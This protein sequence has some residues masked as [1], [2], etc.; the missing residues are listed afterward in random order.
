MKARAKTG[1]FSVPDC[2]KKVL[3][4]FA[5]KVA[6]AIRVCYDITMFKM[7][8]GVIVG[9]AL[10]GAGWWYYSDGGRKDPVDGFTDAVKYQ[11]KE[12]TRAVTEKIGESVEDIKEEYTDAR[13]LAAIK[14]KFFKEET[15][16]GL[17][18]DVDVENGYVSLKGN[19]PSP[20]ARA[21]AIKLVRETE[22]VKKYRANL[23]I[24]RPTTD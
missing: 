5:F 13:V 8:I 1:N 24:D 3:I 20:E 6:A 18:I 14:S 22:G 15:L 23:L 4:R 17:K 2:L 7:M 19:V 10:V 11:T 21:L 12:A 9:L 16:D